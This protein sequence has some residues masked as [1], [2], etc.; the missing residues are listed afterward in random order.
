MKKILILLLAAM[1][2]GAAYSQDDFL[3][4]GE[5]LLSAGGMNYMGDL[6]NQSVLGKVNLAASAGVRYSLNNRLA[7][8]GGVAYGQ[9]EGGNPDAIELR[10]LSFRSPVYELSAHVEFNFFP[11][12]GGATDWQWT[13]YIFGGLGAFHFN[14]QTS[15]PDNE[16]NET[17]VD[18]QPLGTEG[19]NL[20]SYPDRVRYPLNQFCLPFGVGVKMRVTRWFSL[21]AEYGF[22]ATWTDYLDDVSTTYVGSAALS[23]GSP[24][25]GLAAQLADR[26]SEVRQGYVNA[27][28]IKRGDDSLNDWYQMFTVSASFSLD[29]MF[30]WARSKRCTIK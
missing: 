14:P 7:V 13:P 9:I 26:S 6:N 11:Y 16:G 20:N 5:L 27:P 28:G 3:T 30:G 8:A 21:S 19:Q 18:L 22:R 25:G 10:N 4:R 29:T 23:A 17:W 1:T 2:A 12:G 15:Y 24:D